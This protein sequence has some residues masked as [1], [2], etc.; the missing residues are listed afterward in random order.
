[1]TRKTWPIVLGLKNHFVASHT[2]TSQKYAVDTLDILFFLEEN[3]YLQFLYLFIN[4]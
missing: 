4:E 3:R 2:H 1:M